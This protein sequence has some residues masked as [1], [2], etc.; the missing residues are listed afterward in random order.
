MD[1]TEEL[2]KQVRELSRTVDEMRGR[3]AM[4]EGSEPPAKETPVRTRRGFLRMGAA[5]AAGALG[6]AA[7]KAVPAAA[8]TGGYMV[9]GSPNLAENATTLKADAALAG[10]PVLGVQDQNFSQANLD[11]ALNTFTEA[12]SA[13]LRGLG[14]AGGVNGTEGVNGWASG[15]TAYGV[16]GFT[17]AGTGVTGESLSGIGLY[18]R[19]TGRIRQDPQVAVGIPTYSPNNMEQVRDAN[20]VLWIHDASGNWRRVNSLRTDTASGSGAAF[21]PFRLVDTRTL[22]GPKAAGGLYPFT[23]APSGAGASTIP[24]DAVAVVGNLTA[25]GYSGAGFLAIMPQGV[26]YNPAVDPS[27]LNFILGQGAIANAFVCGVNPAN[28]QVQ[29]YVGL[30]S[31]HFII[32]ITAYIQ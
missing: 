7:V 25:T 5:A 4:L 16:Y 22:G 12:F 24:A 15:A 18:A 26:A 20:G 30:H 9:L 6:W 29:V 3:M 32:D 8:A 21:K 28:G 19:T 2:E 11:T 10:A 17:D 31:S 27:S 14:G 23:V 13:P 1:H